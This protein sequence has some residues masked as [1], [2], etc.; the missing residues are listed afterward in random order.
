M[1]RRLLVRLAL[2]LAASPLPLLD[3]VRLDLERELIDLMTPTSTVRVG[4]V[5]IVVH[6]D[7]HGDYDTTLPN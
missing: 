5:V 1:P 6:E 4:P 3:E 2:R 7:A